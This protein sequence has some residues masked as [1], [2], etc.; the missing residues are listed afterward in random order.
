MTSYALDDEKAAKFY[1]K[2]YTQNKTEQLLHLY[3]NSL[4]GKF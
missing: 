3:G 2:A 1:K 4:L